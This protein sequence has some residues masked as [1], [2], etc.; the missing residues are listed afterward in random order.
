MA[1]HLATNARSPQR[2]DA[3]R[4]SLNNDFCA[5]NDFGRS[6]QM[7]RLLKTLGILPDLRQTSLASADRSLSGHNYGY[8]LRKNGDMAPR[9]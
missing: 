8:E 6:A 5:I 9:R 1:L 4:V 2:G 3:A 7:Q